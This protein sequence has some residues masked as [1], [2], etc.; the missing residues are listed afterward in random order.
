V[1]TWR[2]IHNLLN[3]AIVLFLFGGSVSAQ[4][5]AHTSI[6]IDAAHAGW[7]STHRQFVIHVHDGKSYL[8]DKIIDQR[9][10]DS[11]LNA[12]REPAITSPNIENLGISRDWLERNVAP[13]P[14]DGAP[15]QL[16]L[17]RESFCDTER[18]ARLLPQLFKF[19]S[20][21][22]Y[23]SV[24]VTVVLADGQ[25]WFASSKSYYPFMLPW[26]VSIGGRT[27][28]DYNAD[29]SRAVAAMLP[30]GS[31][32]QPRLSGDELR[33]ELARDVMTDIEEQ[34]DALGVENLAPGSFTIL[35]QRFEVDRARIVPYRGY[36]FGYRTGDPSPYE[37]NLDATLHQR[38]SPANVAVEA[39]L[40]FH[41]GTIEGVADLAERLPPY[42]SLVFSVPWLSDYLTAHPDQHLYIRFVHDRSFSRKAMETFEADMRKIGKDALVADVAA[43]QDKAAL[44]LLDY[45]SDWIVLPDKRMILWRHYEP[46]SFLKWNASDF[47]IQRCADYNGNGGGCVGAVILPDGELQR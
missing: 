22:D 46:A 43:N 5:P 45:G 24:Q 47:K 26:K 35:R 41:D 37:E 20:F 30:S 6:T 33:N 31:L 2:C 40:L 42:Q 12:L 44:I 38:N 3:T 27:Q 36:D 16:S 18:I 9:K 4:Q 7:S 29:I 15:T 21:D 23:P 19:V 28:T 1:I 17:F 13:I 39:D 10:V 25:S 14:K 8:G 11:L 32:N 34:W